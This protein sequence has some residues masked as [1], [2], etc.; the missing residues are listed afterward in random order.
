[1]PYAC[2]RL[3]RAVNHRLSLQ[4]LIVAL[5]CEVMCPY[6]GI[7][8]LFYQ[9]INALWSGTLIE[10]KPLDVKFQLSIYLPSMFTVYSS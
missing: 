7:M 9:R 8:E 1:M 4:I 5:W 6:T 10:Y 2:A 3:I